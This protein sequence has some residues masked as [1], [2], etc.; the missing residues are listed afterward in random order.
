VSQKASSAT[1]SGN[2]FR[3]SSRFIRRSTP[4]SIVAAQSGRL[5][6]AR[7]R[8]QPSKKLSRSAIPR[9]L[10]DRLEETNVVDQLLIGKR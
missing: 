9:R 5:I 8:P 6:G 2:R 3:R 7:R 10:H 1:V 4:A